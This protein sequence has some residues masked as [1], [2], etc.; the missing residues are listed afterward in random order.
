[1]FLAGAVAEFLEG[2]LKLRNCTI[3]FG[4]RFGP[5]SLPRFYRLEPGSG[6]REGSASGDHG[7]EA[8]M[9]VKRV[10]LS[11]KTRPEVLVHSGPEPG[12]STPIR[13]KRL[14]PPESSGFGCEAGAPTNLIPRLVVVDLTLLWMPRT[15]SRRQQ[16]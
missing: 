16:A 8:S 7:E 1:M 14:N 15:C 11:R 3:P 6:V 10:R 9:F 12:L 4:E 13:W 2:S 5:W